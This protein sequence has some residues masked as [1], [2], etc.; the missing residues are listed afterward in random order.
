[1]NVVVAAQ[2]YIKKVVE[3][4]GIKVLLLDQETTPIISL[5]TT[6]SALL[7]HEVYLV[8][9][10]TNRNREVM[11]HLKA[12]LLIR[13]TSDN[14]Q[15][16]VEELRDP[17]YGSYAVTFTN[18]LSRAHLERIAE[19]DQYE[20]IKSIHEYYVDVAAVNNDLY[21]IPREVNV[22]G[23]SPE[24]WNGDGLVRSAQSVT[25]VLLALQKRPA[26]RY[27]K[28]S[29]LAQALAMEVQKV[30]ETE[31]KLFTFPQDDTPPV[32]L[33]LDRKNDPITPLLTQWTYQAMVHDHFEIVNGRVSLPGEG[34]GEIVLTA[35]ADPF[36][37]SNMYLNF[38]DL[39]GVI[40]A[41]V[42]SYQTRTNN[43]KKM[44]S[45]ADM[46]AFIEDYPEFRK[47]SGNVS[48]HVSL[49]SELSRMVEQKKLLE[50]SELEQSFACNDYHTNDLKTLQALLGDDSL[51]AD[52]K[53]R[54]TAL[55]ALRYERHPQNSTPLLVNLLK[56][57]NVSTQVLDPLIQAMGATE[58]QEELF[59][60]DS[61]FSK[62]R[63]G[64]KGLKGIENVYTQHRPLLERTILAL[65]KARLSD[66]KY[67]YL[68]NAARNE[69]P[70]DVIIHMIGGAT[71]EEAKVV[72]EMTTQI[73]GLRIVLGS[74]VILNSR[75]F[76]SA[77]TKSSENWTPQSARMRLQR[78]VTQM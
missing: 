45:V 41:Y 11:K 13:P 64:I 44:E 22:Y 2:A 39:G 27:E 38:G 55:Y 21:C 18:I 1:M 46:K 63:S 29:M 54:L 5:V 3:G 15:L 34:L 19:A 60:D 57:F 43:N 35:D 73:P 53:I 4:Q 9:K 68:K 16:L 75:K 8:D 33:I 58:R 77:I 56:T 23:S 6:Q 47:L 32:L 28:N 74:D 76:L 50:V 66:V 48:K 10:I 20:A 36:F 25:S 71:Y 62:A 51:N 7:Q 14:L 17:K 72:R 59:S 52:A 67:P 65:S 70:Q 40:K 12:L 24:D 49:M 61:I 26:I 78:R 42:E 30:I 69:K 31:E 37:A